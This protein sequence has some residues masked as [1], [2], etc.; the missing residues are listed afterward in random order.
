VANI[1]LVED[2]EPVRDVLL[3]EL[4]AMGHEVQEAENGEVALDIILENA[5]DLILCDRAMPVMSGYDLLKRLRNV[6]PQ[7]NDIPFVFLTALADPR[8][9]DVID[10]LN[11]TAY[12]EKPIDFNDLQKALEKFLSKPP[13]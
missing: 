5:P 10:E 1:L 9:R 4:S 12:L 13:Y 11:P 2:E 7:Y 8:D 3:D 6:Y